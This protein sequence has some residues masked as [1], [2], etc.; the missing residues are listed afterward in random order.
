MPRLPSSSSIPS[1]SSAGWVEPRSRSCALSSAQVDGANTPVRR[2]PGD[3]AVTESL[4]SKRVPVSSPLPTLT[5]MV[6][7]G[8]VTGPAV[9]HTAPSRGVGTT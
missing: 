7:S 2:S 4:S 9:P 1:G 5:Y 3:S 6:P 8:P